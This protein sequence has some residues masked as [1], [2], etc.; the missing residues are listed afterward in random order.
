MCVCVCVGGGGG[1]YLITRNFV[2]QSEIDIVHSLLK[3]LLTKTLLLSQFFVLDPSIF[4]CLPIKHVSEF[5]R[6]KHDIVC[7]AVE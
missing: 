7:R 2:S 6:H 5:Q 3:F 1:Y 4:C